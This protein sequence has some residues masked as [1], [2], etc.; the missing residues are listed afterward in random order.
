LGETIVKIS[1]NDMLRIESSL[2]TSK[3]TIYHNN[4]N[5]GTIGGLGGMTSFEVSGRKVEVEN[6]VAALGNNRVTVRVDGDI[7]SQFNIL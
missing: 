1:E 7:V 5:V 4:Q 2:L 6:R 3:V